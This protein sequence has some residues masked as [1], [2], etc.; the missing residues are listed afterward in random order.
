MELM[1]SAFKANGPIPVR[2]TCDGENINPPLLVND[3][4]LGTQSMVLTIEDPDAERGVWTHWL[5]WG[6]PFNTT[7]INEGTVP[8]GAIEGMTDFQ[9]PGYGGPCPPSG[10]H[11]Y[12]F[13]LY[14]LDTTI[15]LPPDTDKQKLKE[16]IEEHVID[17]AE[18]V[19]TYQR[20]G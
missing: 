16:V 12:F 17:K 5:L 8:M 9:R 14:A 18:L 20:S 19:G 3:V 11:R 7:V 4:P 10:M 13:T 2:Y 6:I 1:S 15:D